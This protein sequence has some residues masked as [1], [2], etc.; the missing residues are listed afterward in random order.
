MK[1]LG[2]LLLLAAALF[3]WPSVSTHPIQKIEQVRWIVSS[4]P[5][6][7]GHPTTQPDTIECEQ[8]G[9]DAGP[10][11]IVTYRGWRELSLGDPCPEGDR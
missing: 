7:K 6:F 5:R 2:A 11:K 3:V 9:V 1:R 8:A 4:T 10:T